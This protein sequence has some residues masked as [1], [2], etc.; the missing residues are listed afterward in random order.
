MQETDAFLQAA[1]RTPV[2]LQEWAVSMMERHNRSSHIAPQLSPSTRTLLRGGSTPSSSGTLPTPD[3][4][5][6]EIPIA[7]LSV[8]PE[9]RPFPV[10]A[11]SA[12]RLPTEHH[13]QN[14]M[15]LPTRPVPPFG[16][17]PQ[18]PRKSN[19]GS[20]SDNGGKDSR[21]QAASPVYGHGN[22]TRRYY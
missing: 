4:S 3:S 1:K 2:D 15:D 14:T 6:G 18:V 21:R 22:E 5:T 16:P 20:S 19:G 7:N 9:P 13:P 8:A 17:L 12:S 11:F 10:R